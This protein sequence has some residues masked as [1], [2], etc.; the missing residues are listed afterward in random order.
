MS[1]LLLAFALILGY[2]ET[3]LPLPFGVPG[4]KLGLP[5]LA[6]LLTLYLAGAREAL[7][8]NT[9][10]VILSGFLFGNFASILYSLSGALCSFLV[11]FLCKKKAFGIAGVSMA[12]GCAHNLAQ[13]AVAA[14]VMS[15]W[16]ILYY[17]PPL[18][19]CG[20]LTGLVLGSLARAVLAHLPA[21]RMG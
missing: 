4:M 17:L 8:V 18:I 15:T 14:L 3:F 6:I 7:A 5:N 11:M 20:T 2:V 9:A 21:G 1:G 13:A 16:R 10:R 12:G 19:L